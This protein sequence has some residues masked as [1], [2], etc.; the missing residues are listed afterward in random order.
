MP[1]NC[2]VVRTTIRP[3]GRP[4]LV[5]LLCAATAVALGGCAENRIRSRSQEALQS[6]QYAQAL[7]DLEEGVNKY[8]ESTTLRS[9]LLQARAEAQT[10][11]SAQA[12]NQQ[13]TGQID[14]A[15]K[16]FEQ[17]LALDPQNARVQTLLN[18]L[19]QQRRS[20]AA[21]TQARQL[22]DAKQADKALRLLEQSLKDS[23]RHSGML[24]LQRH[25]LAQQRALQVQAMSGVLSEI[26]PISLDF[27]DASL[28]TVLDVVTR[29][30]GINFVLDKDVRADVKVTVLLRQAKVEDA[31]DLIVGSNQLAKKVVDA[32]TVVIYPNSAEKQR[33]YQEQVVRV[34]HL[35]SSDAKA[36]A[37]FLKAMLKI[38][39]PFV[40]E[41]SNMVALR[42]S[43]ENIQ[44]AERLMAVYDSVEPEVLLEVEV[45]ELSGTQLTAL[46]LSLPSSISLTAVAPDG[47]SGLTLG[48]LRSLTRNNIEVGVGSA[49]LNL[50]REVGDVSTL[51]NPRLRVRNKERAKVMIGDKIP[52]ISATTTS[53]GIVSDSV[54]YLDVGLKLDVEP[55]VY[56][57]DEVGIKVAL[58]V[59][60]LGSSTT[61]NSGTVAYQISTRNASTVLRLRDGETQLLAGLINKEERSSSNRVPGL[62]DLPVLGRLF[63][64]QTDN[65]S[66][67]ELMLAIT[68]HI[69]RNVKRLSASESE[70]W[71]GTDA[72]PR[73][74]PVGGL[75]FS[76]AAPAVPTAG[77][78][79]TQVS[80]APAA[81]APQ[82]QNGVPPERRPAK[83][84]FSGPKQVKVGDT[85]EVK[86]DL[87]EATLRGLMAELA[88]SAD[89]LEL[90]DAAEDDF[91][92]K[93]G[94][95][96]S[97]TKRIDNG[98][99]SLGVLRNQAA[100][101]DGSGTVY[102]LQFKAKAAG[103][104]EVRMSSARP[105][106]LD[107]SNPVL[108][109]PEPLVLEL[110]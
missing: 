62:G 9:G 80:T 50:R 52:V 33:E 41:R 65:G 82:A 8:P 20:E 60:S 57:D 21:L 100:P 18:D 15:Q 88:F 58:E 24:E 84:D 12:L 42:D 75:Q 13:A 107:A 71:V 2:S 54:S 28:R 36:A 79:A 5:L 56:V 85:V 76:A 110:Q 92:R 44:L 64:S 78:A 34:F 93:G 87:S 53:T 17:A 51:A 31:L 61:T 69:L 72:N 96:T 103:R 49:T 94:M 30:S 45:L 67:N 19:V 98:S 91:F 104:A 68:P 95:L 63:S 55:T 16:T 3:L 1:Q 25:L 47:S 26:R 73:L 102:R 29:H 32:R 10:R 99:V 86:V 66:R 39:E 97:F 106:A 83:L 59:S 109:L 81:S 46:G 74:R 27:R 14:A 70:L 105:V 38:R 22:A 23:P 40:D 90:I 11:L 89:K 7:K 37:A 43:A 4:A 48:N 6:G 108:P 35:V 101:A 77:A